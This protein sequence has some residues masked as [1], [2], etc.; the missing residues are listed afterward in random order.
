MGWNGKVRNL[1]ELPILRR[2]PMKTLLR[3]TSPTCQPCKMLAKTLE[4]L[5]LGVDIEVV[6]IS[7]HPEMIDE[8]SIRGVPTLF[9]N[10]EFLVGNASKEEITAW[11]EKASK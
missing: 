3:F 8:Y 11:F 7:V 9:Y 6:D 10:G 5:N 4:E 1:R 2:M